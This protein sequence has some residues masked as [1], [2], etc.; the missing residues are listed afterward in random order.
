MPLYRTGVGSYRGPEFEA[1]TGRP[2]GSSVPVIGL[3][4]LADAAKS[5]PTHEPVTGAA[6]P[7]RRPARA[8]TLFS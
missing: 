5:R 8:S 7:A 6:A 1:R 3:P 4:P 2:A